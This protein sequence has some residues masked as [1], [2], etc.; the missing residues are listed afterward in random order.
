MAQNSQAALLRKRLLDD[1]AEVKQKPYPGIQLHI[2]DQNALQHACL[3]LSP[4]GQV[5][6]HLTGTFGA[7]YPLQ[8]PTIK[9]QSQISHPN[10][11]DDYICASILNTEEGYTS[12]Y[13]LKSIFI[14]LLSFFG[15]ESVEQMHGGGARINLREWQSEESPSNAFGMAIDRKLD[16]H[17]STCDFGKEKDTAAPTVRI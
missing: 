4:E 5:P 11:F 3:I 13:T 15:S 14:Q 8:P 17:C 1:I 12:A 2:E 10:V 16:Y 6:L 9:I 7:A